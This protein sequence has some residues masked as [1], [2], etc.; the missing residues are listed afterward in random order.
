MGVE[1]KGEEKAGDF[2]AVLEK[3]GRGLGLLWVEGRL[4]RT[5]DCGLGCEKGGDAARCELETL[6]ILRVLGEVWVV[7]YEGGDRTTGWMFVVG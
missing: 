4:N 3:W 6:S 5:G 2:G 7:G 1:D